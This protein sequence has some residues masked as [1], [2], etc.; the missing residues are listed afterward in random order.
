MHRHERSSSRL[1]PHGEHG[2]IVRLMTREHGLQAAL[3]AR[4]AGAADAAGPYR[5]AIW[6][7]RHL[8]SRT[9]GATRSRHG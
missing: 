7:R 8:S 3:Y 2:A 9:D 4:R 1:R 6:S 5:R